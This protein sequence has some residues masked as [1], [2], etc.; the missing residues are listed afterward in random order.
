VLI[1]REA[2]CAL[3]PHAGSMCLLDGVERWDETGIVCVSRSHRDSR[4]PLRHAGRLPGLA[5]IEYGAQAA[6]VHGGL[7]A[8]RDGQTAPPAYLAAIR[9]AWLPALDLDQIEEPL[10]V[11]AVLLHADGSGIIYRCA[12]AA[13]GE[14][15]AHARI[16]MLY[17]HTRRGAP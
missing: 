14:T 13:G 1:G 5:A 9:E 3:I 7:L 2:L 15:I 17:W 16:S 12:V 11:S 8:C 4:N 6:A 10:L